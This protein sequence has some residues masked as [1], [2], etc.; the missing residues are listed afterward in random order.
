MQS[1]IDAEYIIKLGAP[2]SLVTVTGNTKFDQTY[3]DVT[4]NE[5]QELLRQMGFNGAEQIFLAGSTHKGEEEIVLK[6][7]TKVKEQFPHSKLLIAPRDIMRTDEIISLALNYN[8]K[9]KKRTQLK[10]EPT[11]D[12]DL[13][14]LDTIG[15]LGKVYSIG[16]IIYVGGSLVAHGGHNILEPAAHGKPI[17]VG[18]NMFNFKETHA[19]FSGRKACITV[20]TV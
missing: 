8:I 11:T 9:G 17:I 5:K 1:R 14:V 19:L 3:T 16:D 20:K 12:H 15:E 4:P 7:F 13:V 18:P 2:P 10:L 6:A